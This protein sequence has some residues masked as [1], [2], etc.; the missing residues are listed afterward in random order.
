MKNK[1]E[2]KN[3]KKRKGP[4]PPPPPHSCPQLP[5]LWYV[6]FLKNWFVVSSKFFVDDDV[7]V[8]AT[9]R[10]H[11]YGSLRLAHKLYLISQG[12]SDCS[13]CPVGSLAFFLSG[14]GLVLM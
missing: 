13:A 8:E 1:I 9:E 12:H 6:D 2:K 4:D 5:E 11:M 14:P 7:V 10:Q 3:G